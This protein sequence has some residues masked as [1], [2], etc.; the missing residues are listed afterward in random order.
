VKSDYRLGVSLRDKDKQRDEGTSSAVTEISPRWN[1]NWAL[2]LPSK[3]K[4]KI[5][6]RLGH[7]SLPTRM[8]ISLSILIWIQGVRCGNWRDEDGGH[9]FLHCKKVKQVWRSLLL[10]DI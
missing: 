1:S 6:W 8:N 7:N 9:L 2:K 4:K 3:V 10:E 5:T